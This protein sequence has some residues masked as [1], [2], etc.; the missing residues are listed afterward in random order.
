MASQS[1]SRGAEQPHVGGD[2]L[3]RVLRDLVRRDRGPGAGRVLGRNSTRA[4]TGGRRLHWWMR[5]RLYHRHVASRV[6]WRKRS[7]GARKASGHSTCG[8]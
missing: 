3:G 7:T 4:A 1:L 8:T 6:S 2:G 5:G